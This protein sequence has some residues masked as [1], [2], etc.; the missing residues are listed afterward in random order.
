MMGLDGEARRLSK[1]PLKKRER[2]RD[3][4]AGQAYGLPLCDRLLMTLIYYRSYISQEFLGYLF[5]LD[6]S[7]V[8]RNMTRMRPVLAQVFPMP[9]RRITA[10]PEDV[11]PL[12]LTEPGN[13]AAGPQAALRSGFLTGA[14]RMAAKRLT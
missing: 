8:C 13:A 9:E 3:I 12:C 7:N 5:D 1:R 6:A 2:Q 11:A 4:G 10:S 14:T